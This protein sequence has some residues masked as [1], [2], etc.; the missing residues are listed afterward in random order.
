MPHG[1][2]ERTRGPGRSCWFHPGS[3]D[4]QPQ[5]CQSA[6]TQCSTEEDLGR[7]GDLTLSPGLPVA[8]SLFG[9]QAPLLH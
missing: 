1:G 7:C 4:Q 8:P 9:L 2:E 6:E 5:T 3:G